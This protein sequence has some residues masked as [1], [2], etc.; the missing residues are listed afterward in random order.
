[1]NVLSQ[2]VLIHDICPPWTDTF[3]LMCLVLVLLAGR[4][5]RR[6]AGQ[7]LT[8]GV[9]ADHVQRATGHV[10]DTPLPTSLTKA[11]AQ[12]VASDLP[13]GPIPPRTAR[14]IMPMCA[15]DLASY[16]DDDGCLSLRCALFPWA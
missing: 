2:G 14:D 6:T 8:V 1:M 16:A 3:L 12:P 5:L 15:P 4:Q 13:T 7:V 11:R 10:R 9:G